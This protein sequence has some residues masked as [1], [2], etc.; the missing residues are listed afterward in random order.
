MLGRERLQG[1]RGREE[2]RVCDRVLL[3]E[4]EGRKE[5]KEGVMNVF[6]KVY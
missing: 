5:R 2:G 4:R 6:C 1:E 3:G